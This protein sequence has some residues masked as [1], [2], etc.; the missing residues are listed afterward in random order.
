MNMSFV[1]HGGL[2]KTFPGHKPEN[3]TNIWSVETLRSKLQSRKVW[4]ASLPSNVE[5]WHQHL[6]PHVEA[7]R[8]TFE[9]FVETF[10]NQDK[11]DFG[12]TLEALLRPTPAMAGGWFN[13]ELS[14]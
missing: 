9:E 10:A 12:K 1:D 8:F 14:D 11:Y 4:V 7:G 13:S 2:G 6:L 5:C 3:A